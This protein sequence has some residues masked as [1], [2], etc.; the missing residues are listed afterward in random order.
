MNRQKIYSIKAP[1]TTHFR[2]ATCEEIDC[3]DYQYGWRIRKE[4]LTPELLHTAQNSGRRYRE[5]HVA[6]GETY[7]VYEAGQHCFHSNRHRTRVERPELFV[8]RDGRESR[9]VHQR[10]EDWMEDLHEH[11]D[12]IADLLKEG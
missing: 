5:M 7:L 3:P 6:Q 8:V 2:P 9:R 4:S 1:L 12:H 11:T 10:P